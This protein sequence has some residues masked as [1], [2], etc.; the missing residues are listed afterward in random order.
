MRGFSLRNT[1]GGFHFFFLFPHSDFDPAFSIFLSF[2]RFSL[3]INFHLALF[4]TPSSC[5]LPPLPL[6]LPLSLR[7]E[8]GGERKKKSLEMREKQLTCTSYAQ[9]TYMRAFPLRN[10][11]EGFRFFFFRFQS[12]FLHLSF[13]FPIFSTHQ[14][15]SPFF[16][17]S[18]FLPLSPPSSPSLCH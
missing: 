4:L 7:G 2:F 1:F 13:L 11:F 17:N 6:L 18:L 5:P 9:V 14:F 8:R 12:H 10:T 3:H 15:P 16:F